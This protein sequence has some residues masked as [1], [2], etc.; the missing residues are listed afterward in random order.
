M[1]RQLI[2]QSIEENLDK[3]KELEKLNRKLRIESFKICDDKQW[4]SESEVNGRMVGMI[5]WNEMLR[6]DDTNEEVPIERCQLVMD[7]NKWIETN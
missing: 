7:D 4:Y 1:K 5:H 6:D 2:E 3:I